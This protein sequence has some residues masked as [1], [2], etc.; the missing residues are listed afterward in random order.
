MRFLLDH[1][2]TLEQS[3]ELVQSRFNH[4]STTCP[5]GKGGL[6]AW[7]SGSTECSDDQ[8]VYIIF[9]N[10]N[11]SKILRIGD[12]TGNPV[13]W[14]TGPKNAIILYSKFEDDGTIKRVTDRWKYCSLWIQ[15][16]KVTNE[17]ELVGKP[18]RISESSQHL[19]GR[20]SPL[21]YSGELLIPLYDEINRNGVIAKFKN[22]EIELLSR[23]G[24]NMIQPTLWIEKEKLCSLS[25]NFG[26][27]MN[28]SLY[29][30]SVDGGITWSEPTQT[31]IPNNN[32]SLCVKRFNGTNYIIWN[33][34][35]NKYRSLMTFGEL[36]TKDDLLIG[37]PISIIG[38]DNGAYPW[39]ECTASRV[40]I[41]FTRNQKIIYNVWNKKSIANRR[42]NIT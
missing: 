40:H 5:V 31:M 19:L 4:C 22:D 26:N 21:I 17:P 16:L 28:H 42:R 37:K 29:C 13:L 33:N 34:T 8:S 10:H 32:S 3:F 2:F 6:V 25:R 38:E 39:M 1:F 20:C 15:H 23:V 14:K 30:E 24:L 11:V 35:K 36:T 18:I 12:K 7:Y 27:N 9:I 41:S